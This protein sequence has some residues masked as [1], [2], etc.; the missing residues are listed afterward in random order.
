MASRIEVITKTGDT[1]ADV[2]K[3]KI[4]SMGFHV[5]DVNLADGRYSQ[6]DQGLL[7]FDNKPIPQGVR[8]D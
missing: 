2:R 4:Q 1:R 7:Y 3:R 6:D 8:L 5:E